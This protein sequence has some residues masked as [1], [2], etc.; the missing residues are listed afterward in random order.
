VQPHCLHSETGAVGIRVIV[1]SEVVRLENIV[2]SCSTNGTKSYH[3]TPLSWNCLW[4][5]ILFE[6][7]EV[8]TLLYISGVR[9]GHEVY[10]VFSLE[11]GAVKC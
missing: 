8:L 3:I 10:G 2:T 4:M 7:T 5:L 9:V 6:Y 1:S 11:L